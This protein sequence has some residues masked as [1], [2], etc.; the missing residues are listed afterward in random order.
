MEIFVHGS[1][2]LIRRS[3]NLIPYILSRIVDNE[4][5]N[6]R[7][8]TRIHTFVHNYSHH[9]RIQPYGTNFILPPHNPIQLLLPPGLC[10]LVCP[11]FTTSN[12]DP[13]PL[14]FNLPDVL[15]PPL[16]LPFTLPSPFPPPL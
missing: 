2:A 12:P 7:G 8:E 4:A 6:F 14:L 5:S 16:S 10:K 13:D 1:A 11:I 15:N 9:D 3:R